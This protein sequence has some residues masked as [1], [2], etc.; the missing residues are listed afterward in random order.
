MKPSLR[1]LVSNYGIGLAYEKLTLAV[2]KGYSFHLKHTGR[3]GDGGQ[4]FTGYWKLRD[5]KIPVVGESCLLV[6]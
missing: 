6:S 4:D 5:R 3:T 2:L 1:L